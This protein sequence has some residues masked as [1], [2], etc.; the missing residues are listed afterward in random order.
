MPKKGAQW[1]KRRVLSLEG[2]E[3]EAFL[4]GPH[5]KE[6]EARYALGLD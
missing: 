6:L 1:R 4:R 3:L 5:C 2:D